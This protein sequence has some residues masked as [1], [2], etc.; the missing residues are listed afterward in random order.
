M[1]AYKIFIELQIERSPPKASR[2]TD[3]RL[4]KSTRS[5]RKPFTLASIC[6]LRQY[7][8]AIDPLKPP[9]SRSGYVRT[10]TQSS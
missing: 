7:R 1:P 3:H 10:S 9:V 8:Q 4:N 5:Q 6:P 2:R